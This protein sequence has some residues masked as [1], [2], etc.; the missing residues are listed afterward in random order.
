MERSI[1]EIYEIYQKY[2]YSLKHSNR[3]FVNDEIH[4][5]FDKI[6]ENNTKEIYKGEIIYM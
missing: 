1:D 2:C 3:F 5:F 6:I 4:R